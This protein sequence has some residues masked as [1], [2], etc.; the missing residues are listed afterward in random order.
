MIDRGVIVQELTRRVLRDGKVSYSALV[1]FD[2]SAATTIRLTKDDHDALEA[3]MGAGKR[4]VMTVRL[5]PPTLDELA[6][7]DASG[8]AA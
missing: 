1:T 7:R 6:S 4:L 3:T 8:G 2:E 5:A